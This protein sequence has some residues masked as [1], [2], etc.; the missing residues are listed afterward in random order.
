MLF[1]VKCKSISTTLHELLLVVDQIDRARNKNQSSYLKPYK[2]NVPNVI[3]F[4]NRHATNSFFLSTWKAFVTHTAWLWPFGSQ[5][6][7]LYHANLAN[8]PPTAVWMIN[9]NLN[10]RVVTKFFWILYTKLIFD[11]IIIVFVATQRP[12]FNSGNANNVA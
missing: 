10:F 5:G 11:S 3:E 2:T 9:I 1:S 8:E 6:N 7:G 4:E 12:Y